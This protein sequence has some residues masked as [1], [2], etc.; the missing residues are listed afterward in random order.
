M[1]K[2]TKWQMKILTLRSNLVAFVWGRGVELYNLF[3]GEKLNIR[4]L[5]HQKNHFLGGNANN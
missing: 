2:T 3:L 5:G 4:Y 1:D